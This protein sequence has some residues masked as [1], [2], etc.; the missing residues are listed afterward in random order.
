MYEPSA[1]PSTFSSICIDQ[2]KGKCCAPWW[3]VISYSIRKENGLSHLQSFK[4]EIVEGILDRA[5]RIRDRY[6]TNEPSP[7]PLFKAPERYNVTVEGI[8]ITGNSLSINLRAMFAFRCLFLSQD[9]RCTIH[10]SMME[11]NDIR[12]PHCGYL[13]SLYPLKDARPDEKGYCRIIHAAANYPEDISKI[14]AA[15][16]MEGAV[17]E[18]YYNEGYPSVEKAAEAVVAKIRGYAQ[19]QAPH[20]L[21]FEGRKVPGRNEPCYCGSG[22]KYKRCHGL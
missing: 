7:R 14:Q 4:E 8:Q 11:G 20:L 2:C 19:E 18:R 21:P 3:G 17:S 13:G 15:I 6:V 10:P 16:E 5:Q 9:R 22:K 1:N 12:P